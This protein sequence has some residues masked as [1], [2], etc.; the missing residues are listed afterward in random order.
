MG[1]RSKHSRL[2]GGDGIQN[3]STTSRGIGCPTGHSP[4]AK[5]DTFSPV[6]LEEPFENRVLRRMKKSIARKI[7]R[8]VEQ[9]VDGLV[10]ATRGKL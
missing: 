7:A 2:S 10:S 3:L 5:D 8:K 9:G 6:G 4:G 1:R